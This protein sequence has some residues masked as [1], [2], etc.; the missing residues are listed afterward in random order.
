M[1]V[2]LLERIENLGQ[3]GDVVRVKPGY[4]R[5][6]LLP[7]RKAMR[8]TEQNRRVFDQ[9]RTQLEAAN[10]ERRKDAGSVE[11]K[12]AGL[13]VTL[14]RQAGEGGHLYGSADARDIAGVVSQA[15]FTVTRQ[16]VRLERPIKAIGIHRVRIALHP[17]VAV[18]ITVNVAARRRRPRS[19]RGPARPWSITRKARQRRTKGR[20][21]R[22][23]PAKAPHQ[24]RRNR[25]RAMGRPRTAVMKRPRTAAMRRRDR[26][27]PRRALRE[28]SF[29]AFG[30]GLRKPVPL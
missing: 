21:T 24:P 9:Q 23:P 14:V 11:E 29:T 6:Y 22:R 3:M 10:L 25:P 4:A 19:R 18:S 8:A 17:E 30:A 16:Q 1:D 12:M 13:A 15:G 20:A 28:E 5:N 7:R 2:I 27:R 26:G